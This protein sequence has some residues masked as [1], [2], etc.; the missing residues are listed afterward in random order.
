M[1][2]YAY[3]PVGKQIGNLVWFHI[4]Y[5]SLVVPEREIESI[6]VA[7][8]RKAP[9]AN[10]VRLDI[11]CRTAQ[12]IHCPDF[13]YVHE[14]ALAYTY[15]LNKNSLTRY[16]NNPFIFHQKHLMVRPDCHRVDYQGAVLRTQQWKKL[17]PSQKEMPSFYLKIGRKNFWRSWLE[18]VGL[19][20]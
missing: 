3:N 15:D 9:E 6:L 18:Q 19:K 2:K 14:P 7:A 5:L 8:K 1:S 17:A 16:R 12:L 10:I 13:D 11:K 20:P 4:D